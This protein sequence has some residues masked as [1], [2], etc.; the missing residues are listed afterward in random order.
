MLHSLAPNRLW[1]RSVGWSTSAAFDLTII[2]LEACGGFSQHTG[3]RF[4]GM[5][6]AP[7]GA[8]STEPGGTIDEARSE[9]KV[10]GNEQN[11]LDGSRGPERPEG[12]FAKLL[13]ELDA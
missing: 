10:E 7:G 11:D 4:D 2:I 6:S 13:V 9:R 5:R 12:A 3:F 8:P 1:G